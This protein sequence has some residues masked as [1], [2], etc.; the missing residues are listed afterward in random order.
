MA[1]KRVLTDPQI[2]AIPGS[3]ATGIS[4]RTLAKEWG[5]SPMTI[6]RYASREEFADRTSPFAELGLTG[7]K[8]FGGQVQD[9]YDAQWRTL[10]RMVPIVKEMLDYPIVAAVM[11]AIEMLMRGA[12]WTVVPGGQ[13]Q[14]DDEAAQFIETCMDDM[15]Q[16]WQDHVSQAVSFIS[17]GFSPFELVYKR[18]VGSDRDPAS[19][20]DDGLIGWR[21]FAVRSQ[22]TLTP[23]REWIFDEA[24]GIQAMNQT[25]PPDRPARR[26]QRDY[27]HREA[28][29]LS[30]YRSQEQS[31]GAQ[32]PTSCLLRLLLRK[33][34]G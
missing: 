18:R 9:D 6:S 27:S 31:A 32:H 11:H 12:K 22:D 29:S 5:V 23:G 13:E 4:M 1:R 2:M 21:K 25:E 30:I 33:E 28:H 34:L 26:P 8:Q 24:G 19:K 20:Y 7:L 15:S 14:A 3:L 16:S 10:Q 17:Y